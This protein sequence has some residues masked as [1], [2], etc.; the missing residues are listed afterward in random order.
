MET[1]IRNIMSAKTGVRREL[2]MMG[3]LINTSLPSGR[4]GDGEVPKSCLQSTCPVAGW[5][6][7]EEE[8]NESVRLLPHSYT[9]KRRPMRDQGS[10]RSTW[11]SDPAH[12]S[13]RAGHLL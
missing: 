12:H 3:T 2:A 9:D 5:E 1:N 10:T 8:E 7:G 4:K 11:R 13:P 6:E